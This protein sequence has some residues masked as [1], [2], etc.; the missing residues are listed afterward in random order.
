MDDNNFMQVALDLAKRGKGFTSPNPMVGAVVVR[1]GRIVGQGYHAAVGKPHAEVIAIDDAGSS[2]R[3]ATLYLTLEPCNHTGRTPPCTQKIL[4]AGIGRVV[5]A[6]RDPNPDVKGGGLAY[7]ADKGIE[8]TVGV[9]EDS[10]VRLNEVFIKYIRTKQ[11]FVIVKCAATLDGRIAT[12]TGDSRWVSGAASRAWVHGLRHAVDAIMV[13]VGTVNADNPS[14]TTR[15]DGFEGNDP[16]RFIIDPRLS[17]SEDARVLNLESKAATTIVVGP[18]ISD[19]KKERL[20]KRGVRILTL[21]LLGNRIDLKRLTTVLA[22]NGITSILVEGGGDLIGSALRTG[23]VDKI[24]IFYAP[25][26]L[27]GDDGVPICRGEGPDLMGDCIPVKNMQVHTFD[28]DIMV[29]GY[30]GSV[31]V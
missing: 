11:P 28:P 3:G 26:I 30:I 4:T 19:E 17:I 5:A 21:P 27:G 16:I 2:A 1:D 7:L 10:A 22:E 6:M 8:V 15:L 13:G 12:R 24:H 29:E 18:Q 9:C 25:K 20:V 23:I 31:S 14:L